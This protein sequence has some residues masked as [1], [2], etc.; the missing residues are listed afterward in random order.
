MV[1]DIIFSILPVGVI[2]SILRGL[3][4]NYNLDFY[5]SIRYYYYLDI[6]S[7]YSFSIKIKKNNVSN[8]LKFIFEKSIV[9]FLHMLTQFENKIFFKYFLLNQ[10][11][12]KNSNSN[13]KFHLFSY[14][15]WHYLLLYNGI[16]VTLVNM[17]HRVLG[18]YIFHKVLAQ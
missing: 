7:L 16:F 12:V 4:I 8:R 2:Y 17:V 13:F 3:L 1:I 11:N 18:W 6:I 10:R 9:S 15:I 14:E 5:I